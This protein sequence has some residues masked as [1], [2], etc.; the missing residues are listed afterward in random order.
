[1]LSR[2]KIVNLCA[3]AVLAILVSTQI[4]WAQAVTP[5]EAQAA[6]NLY[7]QKQFIPAADAFEKIIKRQCTATYCYYAALSSRA[8]HRELR[9]KQLFEYVVKA[10]P[11][12]VEAS[13][14]K[15]VIGSPAT[16][17]MPEGVVTT[18]DDETADESGLPASVKALLPPEMQSMMKTPDGMRAV[19]EIMRQNADKLTAIRAAEKTGKVTPTK[20][21]AASMGI[22]SEPNRQEKGTGDKEHPFTAADIAKQGAAAIDQM[23]YPN[24]WF[25]ASMAALAELPR[26]QRLIASMI[27]SRGKDTYVVRFPGD[28][29]EYVI[30]LEELR[31]QNIHDSALW[32]SLIECA[33]TRKFP[34]NEGA[35]GTEGDMSRLEVGLGCI[36]G[37]KAQ[38]LINLDKLS[39]GELSSFIGS[40]VKSQNPI[41]AGT[42]PYF[43]NL[44]YIVFP[45]HAYTITGFD[46][47][48]SMI[49]IRNPHG[50]NSQPFYL[51][52]DPNHLDFEQLDNGVFKMSIRAFQKYYSQVCRSFI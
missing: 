1:M 8:A 10:F 18:V 30:T 49:T 27:R 3:S 2:I 43:R 39:E 36:T 28:G 47:A 11:T 48:K 33:Q 22:T 40:A 46:P 37:C 42:H 16:A 14:C 20:I 25:E 31:R 23:L 21:V 51:P 32:A 29:H 13:Y 44:P 45:L 6:I 34:D 52:G 50:R 26:G 24:C 5:A 12:S 17:D 4:A 38:V 19:A 35:N 15:K 9:A 41:V 7:K